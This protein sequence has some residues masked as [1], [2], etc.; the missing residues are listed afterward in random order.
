MMESQVTKKDFDAVVEK[1]QQDPVHFADTYR[2]SPICFYHSADFDGMCSGAIVRNFVPDVELVGYN[3]GQPFP[4]DLIQKRRVIMVD[5]S[6]PAKDMQRIC[7]EASLFIWI[8]HHKTAIQDML[9]AEVGPMLTNCRV[10]DAGGRKVSACELTWEYFAED[11]PVPLAVHLL[12]RYDVWDHDGEPRA[13]PF[14]YGAR[15]IIRSIDDEIWSVLLNPSSEELDVTDILQHGKMI[16]EY[17]DSENEKY[18][19]T[20]AFETEIDGYKVLAINKGLTNSQIFDSVWDPEKHHIMSPFYRK[21]DGT[22]KVSLY[23]TRQ[24]VDCSA[25]AKKRGGGGHQQ[26]AGFTTPS[27]PY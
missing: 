27:C 13:M 17:Q 6:L 14:Q 2:Q 3:Y 20:C 21:K 22:W 24:D 26:A 19:K 9:D 11:R 7:D 15:A 4:W 16:M 25:I 1:F 18:A 5:V 12:G 10:A 8:D 23:T